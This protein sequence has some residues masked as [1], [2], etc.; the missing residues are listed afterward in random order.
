MAPSYPSDWACVQQIPANQKIKVHLQNGKALKGTFLE[1]E[2]EMLA[3]L[4][5][6]KEK[7]KVGKQEIHWIGTKSRAKGVM[8]G[9]ILGFGIGA[10]IGAGAGCPDCT[11]TAGDRMASAVGFGGLAGAI[12]AGI[13]AATGVERKICEFP[14]QKNQPRR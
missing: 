2:S 13:G 3:L 1:T 5:S 7:R 11:P 6:G 4:V 12:G 9:A 10:G 8:W 14:A